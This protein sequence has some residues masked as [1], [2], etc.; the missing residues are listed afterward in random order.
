MANYFRK[1]TRDGGGD[2]E[3]AEAG[4]EREGE[5]SVAEDDRND[6]SALKEELR[7]KWTKMLREEPGSMKGRRGHQKP[8][9]LNRQL[10]A[11]VGQAMRQTWE[12]GKGKDLWQLDCLVYAGAA[13]V[14]EAST[15]TGK[16]ST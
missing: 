8:G 5:V 14:S 15:D 9:T 13:I 2:G 6:D 12:E 10:I 1:P 3:P 16:V 4:P 11:R 7:A